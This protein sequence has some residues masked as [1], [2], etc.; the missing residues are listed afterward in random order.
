MGVE[1]R[2][3]GVHCNIQCLYC[4][5]HPQRDAGNVRRHYDLDAMK[6]AIEAEGSMFTLFGGEPLLMPIEDLEA[7]WAWGFERFGQNAVQTNGTLIT[8]E[9]IRLFR[10]Y[11][12]QIGI[13]LDGPEALNDAR[14]HGTMSRTRDSTA[15]SQAALELLC[16]EGLRPSLIIT[17][18]RG[19]AS[20]E[21][22]P[23][24]LDWVRDL[25]R[26]GVRAIRLH[27]LES[28][29][30]LIREKF[31][32]STHENIETL[33][34]FAALEKE[35]PIQFDVFTDMRRMLLGRDNNTTCVWN[36][37]DP[38][39]TRAV[40]GVE[41]NGQSSNC[42]RTTRTASISSRRAGKVSS[43]IWRFIKLRRNLAAAR[44]AASF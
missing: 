13:S 40:R 39:T 24:L 26:L 44:A 10:Q 42:G 31:A 29:S 9:H 16:R 21:R 6:A 12:V 25:A 37:C 14:W 33:L 35:I 32:L 11:K 17:L 20:R 28:E 19:N 1:A 2:P 27:P 15:K 43:V 5:Q 38:Y 36:A 30:E 3:L 23:L 22:L 41:G 34:A 4:Y 18:H 7:L 8:D